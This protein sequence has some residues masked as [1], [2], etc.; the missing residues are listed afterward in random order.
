MQNMARMVPAK[1]VPPVGWVISAKKQKS[2]DIDSK[3][4]P[5]TQV[6]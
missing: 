3:G 1:N 5:H 4:S 6:C 2:D